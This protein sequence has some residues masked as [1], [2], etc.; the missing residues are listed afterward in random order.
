[1]TAN[2]S[3]ARGLRSHQGAPAAATTPA[4]PLATRNR[5]VSMMSILLADV[6]TRAVRRATGLRC[7]GDRADHAYVMF[8]LGNPTEKIWL[9]MHPLKTT[10]PPPA[11]A[12]RA[13]GTSASCA[14][15]PTRCGHIAK[16]RR[17]WPSGP[18]LQNIMPGNDNPL[19]SVD[20]A[21]RRRHWILE[22]HLV[23]RAREIG[24]FYKEL[25]TVG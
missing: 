25:L 24:G 18:V 23:D 22:I 2:T 19:E 6:D 11:S 8:D 16:T 9:R 1:V 15:A 20:P 10:G 3:S 14:P 21:G 17:T 7:Y 13:T 12:S 4:A 5:R